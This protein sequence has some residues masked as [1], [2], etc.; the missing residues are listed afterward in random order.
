MTKTNDSDHNGMVTI[1]QIEQQLKS[2]L[3]DDRKDAILLLKENAFTETNEILN[4][5]LEKDSDNTVR[6]LALIVLSEKGDANLFQTLNRIFYN[7][8]DDRFVRGRAIWAI[9]KM[10]SDEVYQLLQEALTD[11]NEE[12]VFWAITGFLNYDYTQNLELLQKLLINSRSFLI[13]QTVAWFFGI[14]KKESFRELLETQMIKDNHATVRLLCA[15]S[16][17]NINNIHS[18]SALCKAL[19]NESNDL[20]RREI[21]YSVGKILRSQTAEIKD[22]HEFGKTKDIAVRCFNRVLARDHSYIV[23]RACAE[24]LGKL[25]DVRTVPTLIE[26][27]TVDTNQFVRREIIVSL[28]N[29]GDERALESLLKAKRSNYKIIADAAKVAIEQIKSSRKD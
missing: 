3:A 9:R 15:W 16:L 29:M 14:I 6:E 2:T 1:V 20:A 11:Q 26:A 18:I 4:E 25:Y 10:H 12:V 13:R 19:Q 24:G 17:K 7:I 22:T 27:L 8:T 5:I 23:R 28:G 21:T